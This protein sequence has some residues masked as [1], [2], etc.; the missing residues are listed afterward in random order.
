MLCSP[1]EEKNWE[2]KKDDV[3]W[4]VHAQV[5]EAFLVAVD[6]REGQNRAAH[7]KMWCGHTSIPHF[8]FRNLFPLGFKARATRGISQKKKA[9]NTVL[10]EG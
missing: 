5:H 7:E 9:K 2:K 6:I 1:F 4:Y 8:S 3:K 10:K